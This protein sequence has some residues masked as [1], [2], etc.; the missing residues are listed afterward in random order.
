MTATVS[1]RGE[2]VAI[3]RGWP[4]DTEIGDAGFSLVELLV[5][6]VII[7][8]LAAIA[9]PVFMQQRQAGQRATLQSDLRN[10]AVEAETFRGANGTYD[11]F[12]ASP[13]FLAFNTSPVVSISV[14]PADTTVD[15]YCIQAS[16]NTLVW[17]IRTDPV[18]NFTALAAGG[19]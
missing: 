9:V 3:S 13:G 8:I 18:D 15:R 4:L 6:V 16:I 10:L 11:G 17:S 1:P 14:N 12:E 19:C 5:V 2:T 7:G